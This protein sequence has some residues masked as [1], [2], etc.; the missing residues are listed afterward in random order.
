MEKIGD[1]TYCRVT[2]IT[3]RCN[4]IDMFTC[5]EKLFNM[6]TFRSLYLLHR[7]NYY[8]MYNRSQSCLKASMYIDLLSKLR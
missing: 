5:I 8:Q 4:V 3:S 1:I 2:Y 6:S 7:W